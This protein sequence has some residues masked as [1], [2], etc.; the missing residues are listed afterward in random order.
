MVKNTLPPPARRR[1]AAAPAPCQ[2][3]VIEA[4]RAAG[5]SC[6]D[7]WIQDIITFISENRAWAGPVIFALAF[8]ESM[9]FISLLVPF[10]ATIVGAGALVGVGKLDP[11]IV[12]PWGV[13]GASMGDAL[14]YWIGRY[15]KDRVPRM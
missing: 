8:A 7:Q 2:S 13:A 4:A 15:F 1:V 3:A 10:T 6:M 11:W 14:S 5:G 12:I 9:A